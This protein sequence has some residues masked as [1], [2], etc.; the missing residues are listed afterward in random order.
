LNG[1]QLVEVNFGEESVLRQDR[2]SIRTAPQWVGPAL[3]DLALAHQQMSIE[4]NSATDNPLVNLKGEMLHGGNFQAMAVTSAMEKTRRAMHTLGRMQFSQCLEIINPA[5]SR[6]LPPNLVAEDPSTSYIFKGTDISLAALQ[7][8]LGLLSNPINHVQTA[9]MGNQSLNSLALISARYTHVSNDILSQMSAAQLVALCQALDLR[10]MVIG[11]FDSFQ[12][13]FS[14][15]L[16]QHWVDTL[17]VPPSTDTLDN[18]CEN[19]RKKLWTQLRKSF[20]MTVSMDLNNR[21][22]VMSQHLHTVFMCDETVHWGRSNGESPVKAMA[23]FCS[24]LAS[25]MGNAWRIY[26]DAYYI[27]G[28]ASPHLGQAARKMY[29]FIRREVGV[30]F[31]HTKKLSTPVLPSDS[32]CDMKA[33]TVGSYT[34]MVYR[35]IRDGSMTRTI[36]DLIRP[37]TCPKT[38]DE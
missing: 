5:T 12:S 9:D 14:D 17:C 25:S 30:P 34:A 2:Y 18:V 35:A 15:L 22:I 3:E 10:A 27:H 1:S 26:R 6:G 4:C 13:T 21:F 32:P 28:E 11:F 23:S 37:I 24:T 8:E 7:S 36:A 29:H 16:Q 38:G 31:L 19:L 20:D 33:P